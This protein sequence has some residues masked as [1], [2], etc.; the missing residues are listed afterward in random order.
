[1]SEASHR[2][3][4]IIG[5]FVDCDA[6]A[7]KFGFEIARME[8]CEKTLEGTD[9]AIEITRDGRVIAVVESENEAFAWLLRLQGQSVH[10]ATTYGG[11]ATRQAASTPRYN[12]DP[13]GET[14]T[15]DVILTPLPDGSMYS[16]RTRDVLAPRPADMVGN[17]DPDQTCCDAHRAWIYRHVITQE[18]M[19]AH[20]LAIADPCDCG[21]T[22]E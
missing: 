22:P 5:S 17:I 6:R 14:T 1:M 20:V 8:T 10:Y 21:A 16:S 18:A 7:T 9:M 13:D 15:S 19:C 3:T 2:F 12:P 11:Y 4:R